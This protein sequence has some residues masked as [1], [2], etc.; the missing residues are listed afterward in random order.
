MALSLTPLA[1]VV[2]GERDD[3]RSYRVLKFERYG[4]RLEQAEPPDTRADCRKSG[5][6][7]ITS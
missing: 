4:L 7:G 5:N 6:R 3:G 1:P 2:A